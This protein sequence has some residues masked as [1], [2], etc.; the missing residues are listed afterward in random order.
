MKKVRR[1]STREEN[2]VKLSR[3]SILDAVIPD[4]IVS[5]AAA[6]DVRAPAMINAS[7][8]K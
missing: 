8:S 6:R 3:G 4:R 1:I 7:T 5:R 2:K